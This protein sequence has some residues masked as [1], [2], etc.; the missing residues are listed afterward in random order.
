MRAR[1]FTACTWMTFTLGFAPGCRLDPISD[2]PIPD[3]LADAAPSEPDSGAADR[4]EPPADRRP[5]QAGTEGGVTVGSPAASRDMSA[6]SGQGE[7][8]RNG[9]PDASPDRP[10]AVDLASDLSPDTARDIAMTDPRTEG[11]VA[12]WRFDE[13]TGTR[14]ADATGNGSTATLVNGA[15]WERTRVPNRPATDFAIRLDGS[16]D[17]L[18]CIVGTTLPRIEARKSISFWFAPDLGAPPQLSNQRTC[19]A[20]VNPDVPAGLQIGLDRNRPAAWS[21]GENL[22]FVVTDA[23]PAPGVRHVAYT[24]DGTTH[25]LYLDG[26]LVDSS[27]AVPQTGLASALYIGTYA[28]PNELCAG[29][30]DDLR[31]YDRALPPEVIAS[32]ASHN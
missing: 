22:G 1:I 15:A 28:F 10:V 8:Q 2:P 18:S 20:M 14:A 16:D 11:L 27:T 12:H 6:P 7:G 31:I 26:A 25:R 23:V 19:L 9:Q 5:V 24:F 13:A 4:P 30:I 21:W 17:Y 29:Q 3:P 32:L